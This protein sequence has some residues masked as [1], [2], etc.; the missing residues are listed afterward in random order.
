MAKDIEH[1]DKAAGVGVS[2][3][4]ISSNMWA[5]KRSG[6]LI[7]YVENTSVGRFVAYGFFEALRKIDVYDNRK[8]AI[9]KIANTVRGV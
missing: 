2:S 7:G 1:L 8:A 6:A 5:V 3:S 4:Q 9:N